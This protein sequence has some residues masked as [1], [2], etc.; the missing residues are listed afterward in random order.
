[1]AEKLLIALRNKQRG[2]NMLEYVMLAAL[3]TIVAIGGLRFFGNM[4]STSFS[5]IADTMGSGKVVAK[6]AGQVGTGKQSDWATAGSG[7]GTNTN[8]LIG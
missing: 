5:D 1:M 4:L 3:I 2:A 7:T 8:Q 6:A